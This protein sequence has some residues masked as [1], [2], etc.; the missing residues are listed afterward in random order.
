MQYPSYS[1]QQHPGISEFF[2]ES[3][4]PKGVIQKAVL[5]TP[6]ER[7]DVFN[8][9]LVDY[10]PTSETLDDTP[11]SDNGDMAK[12]LATVF[13]IIRQYLINNPSHCIY[14]Q[15]NSPA[16]NRVYRMAINKAIKELC[17]YFTMFGL[18]DHGWEAFTSSQPYKAYL[19]RTN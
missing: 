8:L 15:G 16:R 3:V 5:I 12:V 1:F 6:T 2:F 10:D 7:N 17:L 9:A 19:I 14:F 11:V 4:G 13:Q 18:K